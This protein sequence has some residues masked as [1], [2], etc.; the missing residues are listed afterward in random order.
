[1]NGTSS[2]SYAR[3]SASLVGYHYLL[4]FVIWKEVEE[5]E[6]MGWWIDENQ[7]GYC[8]D[9]ESGGVFMLK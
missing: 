2:E 9:W 1:M 8:E 5:Y 6:K 3:V 4:R 7:Q